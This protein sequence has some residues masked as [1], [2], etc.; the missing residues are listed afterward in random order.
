MQVKEGLQPVPAARSPWSPDNLHGRLL[1]G[2]A[3]RA[4][5]REDRTE[6]LHLTRLTL[7]M[8]RAPPMTPLTIVTSL[9]RE[10][11]RV[12][13]I[14]ASIRAGKVEIAKGTALLLRTAP[15][16]EGA[17]WRDEPWDVEPPDSF[18][19]PSAEVAEYGGWDLRPISEGGFLSAGR[20]QVWARDTWQLV[21]GEPM[22]PAV[23][24]ALASDLPNPL[25]NSGEQ[26]LSFINP[27]LTMFLA[28]PPVSEWIGLEVS[29][30]IGHDGIAV[31]SC[32]LYDLEGPIGSSI[33]TAIP[34]S[35][36]LT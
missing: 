7:D 14:A 5:E 25:A 9:V 15:H 28:R 30:H 12:H 3:A 22:S 33:V 17:V 18:P 10:G 8:F 16:P 24:A 4:V 27:D 20:K 23:R 2:L 26:G 19:P 32:A 34:T 6:G 36:T 35:V 11:Q 29:N 31:G 13:V 21:E 1:A